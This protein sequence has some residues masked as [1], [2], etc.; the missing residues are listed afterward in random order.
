M[1]DLTPP[2]TYL[3]QDYHL[4]KNPPLCSYTG[5]QSSSGPSHGHTPAV[6]VPDILFNEA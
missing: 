6:G 2:D 3:P 5:L 1:H 4:D